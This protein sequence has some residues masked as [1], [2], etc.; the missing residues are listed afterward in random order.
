MEKFADERRGSRQ[1]EDISATRGYH[2]V[3]HEGLATPKTNVTNGAL[4]LTVLLTCL[5]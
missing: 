3:F 1:V 5:L 2:T 4:R